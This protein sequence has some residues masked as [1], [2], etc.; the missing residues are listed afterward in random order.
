MF[1]LGSQE[2]IIILVIGLVIFGA[3]NLPQMGEG[4]GKAI[5]N[6]KKAATEIE[7]AIDDTPEQ[8]ELIKK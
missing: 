2:I 1:G 3:K 7:H 8:D 4:M 5:K 6:F